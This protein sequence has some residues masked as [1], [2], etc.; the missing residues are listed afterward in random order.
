MGI[1]EIIALLLTPEGLQL[2]MSVIL[3]GAVAN[4]Y[5]MLVKSKDFGEQL[6]SISAERKKVEATI[7]TLEMM[8]SK[9]EKTTIE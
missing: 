8:L 4:A 7:D 3:L 9:A 2:I 5:K 1:E 6:E